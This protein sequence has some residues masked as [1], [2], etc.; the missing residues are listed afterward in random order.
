M[1]YNFKFHF[2]LPHLKPQIISQ[3]N[4]Y[5][6]HLKICSQ[7][8][9]FTLTIYHIK[10]SPLKKKYLSNPYI[11]IYNLHTDSFH[12]KNVKICYIFKY[13]KNLEVGREAPMYTISVFST[14][15]HLQSGNYPCTLHLCYFLHLL[16][17]FSPPNRSPATLV[18]CGCCYC[19]PKPMMG[20]GPEVGLGQETSELG[21]H[22]H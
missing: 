13:F 9:V 17:S 7:I 14:A 16:F 21:L 22:S 15:S 8:N 11:H 20:P 5:Q 10:V 4:L 1:Y 12:R 2:F 18:V 3:A 6:L 19:R